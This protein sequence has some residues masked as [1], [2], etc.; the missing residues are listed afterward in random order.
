[1]QQHRWNWKTFC[2]IKEAC[3]TK[4]HSTQFHLHEMS[5]INRLTETESKLV[6]AR[7]IW[8]VTVKRHGVSLGGD[9]HV[10]KL[11]SGDGYITTLWICFKTVKLLFY[12]VN[13]IVYKLYIS[14]RLLLKRERVSEV[15]MNLDL[16]FFFNNFLI[17]LK[18]LFKA[19]LQPQK[20]VKLKVRLWVL[21]MVTL[22]SKQSLSLWASVGSPERMQADLN[23]SAATCWLCDLGRL[24]LD[25]GFWKH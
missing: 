5:I 6:V 14:I 3:H 9:K 22:N 13:F 11:D 8:G 1:M 10:L 25:T 15:P 2:Q 18:Y 4:P 24:C 20:Q 12:K 21:V 7:D 16:Q 19:M 23:P 17:F